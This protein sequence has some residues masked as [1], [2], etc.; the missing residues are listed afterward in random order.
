MKIKEEDLLK[1]GYKKY[2]EQPKVDG[3]VTSIKT[4]YQKKFDEDR[5]IYLNCTHRTISTYGEARFDGWEFEIQI[6]PREYGTINIQS[7][8]WFNFGGDDDE[9]NCSI[10]KFEELCRKLIEFLG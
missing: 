4:L 2:S 9:G 1:L 7:V 6:N 8:Q 3:I 5:D 10:E